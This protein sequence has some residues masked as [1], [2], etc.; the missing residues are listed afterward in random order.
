MR[1]VYWGLSSSPDSGSEISGK[2]RAQRGALRHADTFA[3]TGREARAEKGSGTGI[4]GLREWNRYGT[5]C[6]PAVAQRG[7]EFAQRSTRT[8]ECQP[9]LCC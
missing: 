7:Y 6:R 2:G 9:L 4:V 5:S 8:N 1:Y 3:G